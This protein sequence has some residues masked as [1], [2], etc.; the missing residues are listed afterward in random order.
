MIRYIAM[1]MNGNG[2]E[3]PLA[4]DIPLS[5]VNF[6]DDLSGS[7][8]FE[9]KIAPEFAS[10]KSDNGEPLFKP[11]STSLYCEIDGQIRAGGIVT[12]VSIAGSELSI[13]GVG[14]MGYFAG[15]VYVDDYSTVQTDPLDIVR[16]I[17]SKTQSKRD[18]NIGLT[19]DSKTRTPK[20][21]GH[22][23]RKDKD[24]NAAVDENGEE[25]APY[26]LTWWE[27][28]DLGQEITDLAQETPFDYRVE[29]S[30]N[31]EQ[32]RKNLVFGYPRLGGRKDNLRFYV[33]ENVLSIPG[34]A[35]EGTEY[36]SE[37]IALGAGEGRKMVRGGAAKRTGRLR[38]VTVVS[39]KTLK[40]K[41]RADA[42]ANA[43]LKAALGDEDFKDIEVSDHPNAP[44]G[45][46]RVGDEIN[47]TVPQGWSDE[48]NLWVRILSIRF[49][50]ETGNQTLTVVRSEKS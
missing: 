25:L 23:P 44:V 9:G 5:S 45:T 8:A 17:I 6:T 36:A 21:L 11:W 28:K 38:R 37:V 47:V 24:G 20:R 49:E 1:R 15:M 26:V 41:A 2:T 7:G 18:G 39:D 35:F 43:Q 16:H 31:G 4:W 50:P 32:V 12:D 40:N 3:T 29:L 46:Y 10:L 42:L 34:V 13:S 22:T 48:L 14:F 33:G 27:S 30:W 19:V